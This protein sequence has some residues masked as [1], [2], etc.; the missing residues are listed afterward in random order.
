MLI[1]HIYRLILFALSLTLIE[2][3]YS[4]DTAKIVFIAGNKS[5]GWGAH[6]FNAG[7]LLMEAHLKEALGSKIETVVHKNGWPKI[8]NPFVGADAIILFMDGGG[9]HPINKRLDQVKKEIDRGCGLMCMHYAVEVP[10][11][12]SGKA[13]QEWIGGYYETGWSINPHWVAESKLNRNHPISNGVVDFKVKD[14]W[15][16][17]MRFREGKKG[18]TNILQAIPD[19]QARSGK[20][21]WPR[22]PKKHIVDASGR[23]E[24][25]CWSV[26]RSDGGRGVGFTGAH[27]HSNFADDGFRKLVLNAVAWTAG[28]D[29]PNNG[30]VTHKPNEAELDANQDFKKPGNKKKEVSKLKSKKINAKFS[31]KIITENTPG[32]SVDV[33]VDVTG[34]DKLFLVV[35]DAGDGYTADWADWAEPR[36]VVKGKEL[37]LTD[38]KWKSARVDWGEA[39]VGKNA[40]GGPL[41]INGKEVNY[42]IGVHANSVLEYD[43]P[44]GTER[45]KA[46]CG[47]DN[48][49]SDQNGACSVRF[50]VFTEKPKIASRK[51]GPSSGLEPKESLELLEVADGMQAELFASEPM[52]LSPA[53][54]DV[55]HRGRVWVAEIVN[56]RGHNGKR[57]E[58]DRIII[59]ED[60]NSDGLADTVKTFYQG[61]DIDSPHGVCVLGNKVIV[62]AGEQVLLFTDNNGDDKPDEKK[63]LFNV[64]GGKQHDHGIHA[65]CFGP[66]GKLYFNFGNASRGLKTPD[67]KIIIDKAGNEIRDH[68]KPYQQGMV[69]RCDLDGSNVET[70][71]WNFRNNWEASV[72]SFGSIWQ[73]DNDDDGNRG[74]RINFVMEYGNYGY[75]DEING[76]G[77]RDKRTNI[78]KEIPLRH[79][80]LNDPGVIPNLLQTGAGSPTGIVVYE[81]KMFPHLINQVIH[82]DAGPNVCRAYPRKN[83]GAGYEATMLPL[84]SGGGDRW[85]RPSDV[86]VGPDGSL[87]VADWYDPGVG[88]HG[89]RDLERGRIFRLTP[90]GHDG[91]KFEKRNFNSVDGAI[92]ALKSPD[93]ESRY[94]AW[95]ALHSMGTKKTEDSLMKMM[96][97]KDKVNRARAAWCLGKMPGAGNKVIGKIISDLDSDLRIV[98]IRLARQL[99]QDVLGVISKLA[100]DRSS[101]VRRECAIALREIDGEASSKLWARLALQHDGNDRWYLEALGI[102]AHGKWDACFQAWIDSGGD[103]N[104][105]A[106]KDIVWRSRSK[107][108]PALLAKILKN[109][110]TTDEDKP[111]YMRA[112]DFH[113]GPEKDAALQSILLE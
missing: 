112:F 47:L 80:H 72:D 74:V 107:K 64:I 68:R 13:L 56:Y 12:R 35:D 26:E 110:G 50:Q 16:F 18:V 63:V 78:E 100:N 108:A 93:L 106:G 81:G 69:F 7:S 89:M 57:A 15:Y 103:W 51:S 76:R 59:L 23:A 30:L 94:L 79:W 113:E 55:D 33:D 52:M 25:L 87:F 34:A 96:S 22:G 53:S 102:G 70:L 54:I 11:G 24:T 42:G 66:D 88:G 60:T 98:A 91:Y 111:R 46:T 40:G 109:S 21:S 58:G 5:H 41:R 61:R 9:G 38:L 85:Y 19:D 65:F 43:L 45:F 86:A 84:L 97:D 4:K 28:L 49:G 73:S 32:H 77:W 8:E 99:N 104:T 20:S 92:K 82:C 71:G 10:V 2:I 48:G 27:F 31:S 75:R 44:K 83:S 29:V 90:E 36:I 39:R 67:D 3:T 62:S 95:Q 1:K 37:K 14:E 101:Q 17:N 6:E 105:K